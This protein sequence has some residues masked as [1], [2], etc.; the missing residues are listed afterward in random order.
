MTSA[1]KAFQILLKYSMISVLQCDRNLFLL[2]ISFH[3]HKMD[4]IFMVPPEVWIFIIEGQTLEWNYRWIINTIT[5]YK[6]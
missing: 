4:Q 1:N 6:L 5:P 3:Q 2:P